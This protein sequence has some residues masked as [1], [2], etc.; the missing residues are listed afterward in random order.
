[1]QQ[2][3]NCDRKAN[4]VHASDS[5]AQIAR[6]GPAAI[7][8]KTEAHPAR[9]SSSSNGDGTRASALLI[10][11]ADAKNCAGKGEGWKCDG[12]LT[13]KGEVE[14]GKVCKVLCTAAP[15]GNKTSKP[16]VTEVTCK[17]GAYN[18]APKCSGTMFA[19]PLSLVL[20]AALWCLA[21]SIVTD[22]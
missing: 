18:P 20:A 16:N 21:A 3:G 14:D 6:H 5:L 19:R 11:E 7:S 12:T 2:K 4:G 22:A 13:D 1:M 17:D 10:A 8:N 9:S 15:T